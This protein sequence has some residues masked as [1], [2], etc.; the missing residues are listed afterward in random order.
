[1]R[2]VHHPL[3]CGQNKRSG[4]FWFTVSTLLADADAPTHVQAGRTLPRY[5]KQP[6]VIFEPIWALPDRSMH[7]LSDEEHS[8]VPRVTPIPGT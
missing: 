2:V 6:A 8:Q 1:M 5:L 3:V 4:L 7:T